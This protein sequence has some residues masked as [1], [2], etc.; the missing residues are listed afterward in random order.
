MMLNTR[1]KDS[2]SSSTD[3][4]EL[5]PGISARFISKRCADFICSLNIE[6]HLSFRNSLIGAAAIMII[7]L[8]IWLHLQNDPSGRIIFGDTGAIIIDCI[9]TLCLYYAARLSR[10]INRRY[11]M[12]WLILAIA[13]FSYAIGDF[14]WAYYEIVLNKSPFPSVADVPYILRYLLFLVA[15]Y[16]LPAA[17]ISSK[18]RVKLMLDTGSVMIASIILFWTL[19]IAPTIVQSAGTDE[20]T[21]V[22]SV[23]YPVL[24]LMLLFSLI[25]LLL[26]RLG[27]PGQRSIVLLAAGT[28]LL[29]VTDSIFN[30][31]SLD[32]SYVSGGILDNGWIASYLIISLAGLSQAEFLRSCKYLPDIRYIG[33][34]G[35]ISWP[36]YLPYL[37]AGAAFLLLVWSHDHPLSVS[38]STLALAVGA[39]IGLVIVRQ[40]I[41]L[42]E[43]VQLYSEA[44]NEIDERINAEKEVN[45]LNEELER[46]V[47]E[48]T[49]QLE[50]TNRD[51][52]RQ[53][54]ERQA[55]E[56][57]LMDSEHRFADIIDFLPDATFV[58]DKSGKVI[59]WNRAIEKMTG[60]RADKILGAGNYEYSL[61][62]YNERRPTLA[63]LVLD[64]DKN[65]E[66][67]YEGVKWQEEDTIV[68]EFFVKNLLGK[69][70]Y[71][72][73]SAAILRDSEGTVYGAIESIREITDRMIAEEALKNAKERAESATIAKSKFL[74]NMS[75]EIR[76]PMNA[77]IGMSDLLLQMDMKREQR[78]YLEII[79]NS[80]NA[81]LS[82]INDILD[83]SKI[84][85]DKLELEVLPFDLMNC[86][87][88]SMDLVAAKA[89]EKGLEMTYFL[90]DEVPARIL[91]DEIRLRQILINL[92]GN[93]VKFTEKGEVILAVNSSFAA[94]GQ[95]RL[96]FEVKDTGIGISKE[97]LGKLFQ[98]F[99]QVDSS[100]TRYYGGTG[101]GLAISRKLV[102]MMGGEIYAQ[103]T[104]GVGSTFSFT[105]LCS[106]PQDRPE[107]SLESM[108]LIGKRALVV[109][110]NESVRRMLN[111][112][113]ASWKIESADAS[114]GQ[115]AAEMIKG[116]DFDFVII[117][118][119]LPDMSGEDLATQISS[120]RSGPAIVM[121]S[122]IG[123]NVR[124]DIC[125]NSWLI[126]PIKPSQLKHILIN[127][128]QP[129]S[130]DGER[131]VRASDEGQF[132]KKK[133]LS[134]LLVE[135]NPVNQRVAISMLKHLDYGADI[136]RNGLEALSMIEKKAYDIILMDIQMP[137][138][139]GLEATRCI[140]NSKIQK[141]PHI[142]AMTAYALDGDR[143]AFL[144]AGMNDYLSKPIK[145]EELKRAIENRPAEM[146]SSSDEQA[147][148]HDDN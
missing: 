40:I 17:P 33:R 9:T 52:Q 42:N 99:S 97:N 11:Y 13:Q 144:E 128:L 32:G 25:D 64:H 12:S 58:I 46:R 77:V 125:E 143:E 127:L 27:F 61:P 107:V 63:D 130:Q 71:L 20:L 62:F 95:V 45:K 93:A 28:A 70:A 123:S 81:L 56:E 116:N 65:M 83:Y 124:R 29:I 60:I 49:S 118:A 134:I 55:A 96:L 10:K 19:I 139:D 109:E 7:Y 38:F 82:V 131:R 3:E 73:A 142:I 104:P 92:L 100:T 31:L 4:N 133:E 51:L 36:L 146:S 148:G 16:I 126:K 132:Q 23:A 87:E 112:T 75:H 37:A 115:E 18:E 122:Q 6:E 120:R 44:Q 35:Q 30:R 50:D 67:K 113:L 14:L 43:N 66:K 138:M 91:G 108:L 135:D 48:R 137:D 72:Q 22:L 84:D 15:I 94:D 21:I 88:V 47:L 121:M 89:A 78:D 117:D 54:H 53:I 85:G 90:G 110:G 76:T 80:G 41:V 5:N 106:I 59:S 74:A 34:Y 140:R 114:S 136:A 86:I 2:S 57:A 69:P 98:F 102:E 141:Q 8:A 101:L 105:I 68:G 145:I 129:E 39:I 147:G 79:R 119:T 24:D 103:S 111:R 1:Q 26:R